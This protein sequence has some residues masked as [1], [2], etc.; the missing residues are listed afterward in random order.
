MDIGK[1]AQDYIIL[2]DEKDRIKRE[3]DAQIREITNKMEIIENWFML[4]ADQEKVDSWKTQYGTI[5]FAN[6]DYCSVADW[7][8]V[9]DFVKANEAYELLTK[10][11]NKTAVRAYL[12]DGE[13]VPPGVNWTVMRKLFARKPTN[14]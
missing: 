1:A 13:E 2:R 4:K 14:K 7:D 6:K 12:E 9:L 10:G 8:E 5:Y 3:A 11:V